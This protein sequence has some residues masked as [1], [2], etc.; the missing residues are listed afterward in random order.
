MWASLYDHYPAVAAALAEH[1]AA[2][3]PT[4]RRD[5]F[6]TDD[7]TDV[8]A[9]ASR[10]DD[11]PGPETAP[12]G[13]HGEDCDACLEAQDNCRYHTG[14]HAGEQ[15]IRELLTTLAGD[16]I[17]LDHLQERHT[18]LEQAGLATTP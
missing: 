1:L 12:Y 9:A 5:L 13:T 7:I 11:V 14:F 16:P 8:P 6:Q 2:L 10:S 15:Y 17:A 3:P 4:W 18:E